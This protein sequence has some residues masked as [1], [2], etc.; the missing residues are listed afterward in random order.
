MPEV[1]DKKGPR[2][3]HQRWWGVIFLLVLAVLVLYIGIYIYQT[4]ILVQLQQQS[5]AQNYLSSLDLGNESNP[6]SQVNS[7][8]NSST[9]DP[10]AVTRT[11]AES[12]DDPFFGSATAKIVIVEFADFQCPY[13]EQEFSAVNRIRSEY[14]DSIKFIYRDFINMAAHPD[15]LNAALAARCAE[16]QKQFWPY[17]D[18]LFLNQDNL[19]VDNLKA[20]AVKINLNAEAFNQCLDSQKYLTKVQNDLQAGLTL[21]I[22]G[23]PTFYING[24]KV[25]GVISYD[26]FKTVLDQLKIL[27]VRTQPGN[28]NTNLNKQL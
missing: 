11:F 8:I 7:N 28:L 23:T 24:Y 22:G 26:T 13:C 25:E 2:K 5:Y 9:I 18:Q 14:G 12:A 21:N 27:S 16:E 17:H 3:W 10:L 6:N 19:A 15:A 20:L 1:K 4:V